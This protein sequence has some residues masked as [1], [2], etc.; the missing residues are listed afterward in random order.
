[1]HDSRFTIHGSY[2]LRALHVAPFG[3]VYADAVAL[4]DEG[5]DGD[6]DAVLQLGRLVDVRDGGAFHRR[7][8]RD[9]GEFDGRREVDADGRALVVLGLNLHAR[10]EPLRHVAEVVLRE[11]RLLVVLR[12][13]EVVVGAV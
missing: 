10:R 3:R 8:G 9:H 6:G 11:R 13:H 2:L 5:G 1:M 4:V 12:V 7:L